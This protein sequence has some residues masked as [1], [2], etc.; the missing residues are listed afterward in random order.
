MR[1]A[2]TV[3]FRARSAGE[4]DSIPQPITR[5]AYHPH[6][7]APQANYTSHQSTARISRV[8]SVTLY[9][10]LTNIQIMSGGHG[11]G[12]AG[13][14]D[15]ASLATIP[16]ALIH[17]HTDRIWFIAAG[18]MIVLAIA[19]SAIE[20]AHRKTYRSAISIM[21]LMLGALIANI[22][23]A[24]DDMP[25]AFATVSGLPAA[26]VAILSIFPFP[27]PKPSRGQICSKCSYDLTALASD[28][29]CPECGTAR[30]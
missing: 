20:L 2:A 5:V 6:M 16:D 1:H 29:P 3:I 27:R 8:I 19:I 12:P 18:L 24:P 28:I 25:R 26:A 30:A 13:I 21:L 11:V 23:G 4:G 9:L 17:E 22:I 15:L 7:R 10:L 14:F